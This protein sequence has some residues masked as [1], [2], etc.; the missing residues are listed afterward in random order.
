MCSRGIDLIRVE[1]IPD[2]VQEIKETVIQLKE[3]VGKDGIVFTSGGIGPTH[4]DVTYEAIAAAFGEFIYTRS[5]FAEQATYAY[6]GHSNKMLLCR[7][8]VEKASADC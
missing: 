3:R 7:T 8:A 1:V 6:D 4:D 2:D 5:N